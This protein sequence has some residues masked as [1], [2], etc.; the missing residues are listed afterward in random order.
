MSKRNKSNQWRKIAKA[1]PTYQELEARIEELEVE[2]FELRLKLSAG[3][4]AVSGA[5]NRAVQ[6]H[7]NDK[8]TMRQLLADNQYLVQKYLQLELI[9]NPP[10][11]TQEMI[12]NAEQYGGLKLITSEEPINVGYIIV[13]RKGDTVHRIQGYG[14]FTGSEED[15]IEEASRINAL[16]WR[17]PTIDELR[18]PYVPGLTDVQQLQAIT[19]IAPYWHDEA[20]REAYG[21]KFDAVFREFIEPHV[22]PNYDRDKAR[23]LFLKSVKRT[24]A[25]MGKSRNINRKAPRLSAGR[26]KGN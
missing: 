8:A 2:N 21:D 22:S 25:A 5:I 14:I 15:F 20:A 7:R 26:R 9:E 16:V 23:N 17:A 10:K 18:S 3:G 1:K 11:P 4:G 6:E 19:A 24:Y 12:D 13:G